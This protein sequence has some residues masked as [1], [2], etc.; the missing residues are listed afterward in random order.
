MYE[1]NQ[2]K[3]YVCMDIRNGKRSGRKSCNYSYCNVCDRRGACTSSFY[4]AASGNNNNVRDN[5]GSDS[6][7]VQRSVIKIL[8]GKKDRGTIENVLPFLIG[9]LIMSALFIL[10]LSV[11]SDI[12]T[13][14][15]LDQTARRAVL[16]AETYG[17]LD[18]TSRS[19]L[20]FELTEAGIENAQITVRGYAADGQWKAVSASE[21]AAYGSKVEIEVTGTVQSRSGE[22]PVHLIRTS[23]SKN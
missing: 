15:S 22:T 6:Q 1:K 9:I 12:R 4:Y 21:P 8:S 13:K 18:D 17:Y 2:R 23:T 3:N 11:I 20:M 7:H 5:G 10:L 19:D 14:N 16:L